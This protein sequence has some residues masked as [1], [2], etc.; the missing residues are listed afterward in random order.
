MPATTT[1]EFI[2]ALENKP[3]TLTEVATALGKANINI[4]GFQL[5]AQGDFG[6]FRFLTND[7]TKT[8]GWLRSTRHAFRVRDIVTVPVE[9]RPGELGR[10]TQRLAASGVNVEAVYPNTPATGSGVAIVVDSVP[11]AVK[12]LG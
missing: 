10:I 11:N 9:N 3:G 7:P 8:E 4:T 2:I 1:K 5:Q 6:Q 12:A